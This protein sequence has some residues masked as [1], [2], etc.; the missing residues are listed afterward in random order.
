[1]TGGLV[2]PTDVGVGV[3][4]QL[5]GVTDVHNGIDYDE[6]IGTRVV[7]A[8]AEMG[9]AGGVVIAVTETLVS[10]PG[11]WLG[12][13][14]LPEG[15]RAPAGDSESG[16][17]DRTLVGAMVVGDEPGQVGTDAHR[18]DG[19]VVLVVARSRDLA[20]AGGQPQF[21][22]AEVGGGVAARERQRVGRIESTTAN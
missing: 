18:D 7:F 13:T 20:T 21:G 9:Q 17:V 12:A 1:L 10:G 14:G 3:T 19:P 22:V 15:H 11:A 8:G 2:E 4:V 16:G 6:L 5:L